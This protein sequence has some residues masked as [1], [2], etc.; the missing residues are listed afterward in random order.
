MDVEDHLGKPLAALE[1][2]SKSL[3][4]MKEEVLK[5]LKCT[6]EEKEEYRDI[7]ISSEN[8]HWIVTVPAIWDDYAKKFMRDAAEKVNI[9]S[10]IYY[11]QQQK[12]L[13]LYL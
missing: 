5:K 8:I 4:Y 3:C 1:V 12:L 9:P 2:F 13:N 10:L 11:V 6:V 7:L